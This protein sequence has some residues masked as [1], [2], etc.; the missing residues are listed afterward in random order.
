MKILIVADIHAGKPLERNDF[1]RSASHK[2]VDIL[3]TLFQEIIE[4]HNPDC[5]VNLGDLIRSESKKED[6]D[7]YLKVFR[8]FKCFDV[9]VIHLIGNHE[10]KTHST[11]EI[12][13]FWAEEGVSQKSF[14]VH[15]FGETSFIWLGLEKLKAEKEIL[16]VPDDQLIWLQKTLKSLS[17]PCLIFIH[18]PFD[19]QNVEGNFFATP[20]TSPLFCA[21]QKE[22]QACL[23]SHHPIRAIFQAHLHYF[24]LK[25]IKH[26]PF[27]TIPSMSENLCGPKVRDNFPEIYTI[28]DLSADHL[29]VNCYSQEYCFAGVEL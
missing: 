21:N 11:L 12:E 3:P 6:H 17:T 5:V 10:L 26:I 2:A 25:W 7:R 27:F 16:K 28:V 8:Y 14:G 1:M 13:K 19:E 24:H 22:I 15:T 23:I 20:D 4:Q 18:V 29:T 9:P